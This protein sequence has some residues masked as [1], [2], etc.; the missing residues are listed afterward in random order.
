MYSR[1][2]TKEMQLEQTLEARLA[3]EGKNRQA[4]VRGRERGGSLAS[5]EI[6]VLHIQSCV[7]LLICTWSSNTLSHR[8][9][10]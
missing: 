3:N 10:S 1:Q 5:S 2:V 6:E 8:S 7:K 4:K 9:C